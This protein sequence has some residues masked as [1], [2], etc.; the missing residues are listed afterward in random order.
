MLSDRDRE[1]VDRDAKEMLRELNWSIEALDGA[2]KVR[3]ETEAKA[4]QKKHGGGL[5]ALGSWASGGLAG[6]KTAEYAEAEAKAEEVKTHRDG[7]LWYLRRQLQ[8]C[9]QTQKAMMETRLA[10]EIEMNRSMGPQGPNMADFIEFAPT[11][12]ATV[13]DDDDA[14]HQAY[15]PEEEGLSAEQLQMFEQGN[16]DMMNF[17]ESMHET[18]QY[19]FYPSS[20]PPPSPLRLQRHQV[21]T[22]SDTDN[23]GPRRSPWPRS[24]A[25]SRS[26]ST[27]SRR[28][29]SRSTCWSRSR[30]RRRRM[31]KGATRS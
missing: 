26:S 19:V 3:Y 31:W 13:P 25:S 8:L 16:Q 20:Q 6:G 29:Q 23:T 4:I 28:R 12:R 30:S 22:H 10:R 7:V 17:Y 27:T 21:G 2:E 18:V 14:P 11:K 5:G 24:A 15:R 1:T 9:G